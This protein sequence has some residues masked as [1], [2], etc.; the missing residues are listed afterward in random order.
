MNF[1]CRQT[2]IGIRCFLPCDQSVDFNESYSSK[3][4]ISIYRIAEISRAI[5]IL[6]SNRR[7]LYRWIL[8]VFHTFRISHYVFRFLK[9]LHFYLHVQIQS[10]W[11]LLACFS[12][13]SGRSLNFRAFPCSGPY[14]GSIIITYI[15]NIEILKTENVFPFQLQFV[16]FDFQSVKWISYVSPLKLVMNRYH[17]I[18]CSIFYFVFDSEILK[19]NN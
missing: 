3:F 18:F 11:N 12:S 7:L 5:F 16:C 13:N 4:T 15:E 9:R 14:Y 10:R 2:M 17:W 8:V 6:N 19:M 1:A